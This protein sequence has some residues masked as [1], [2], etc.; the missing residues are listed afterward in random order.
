MN[1]KNFMP[2]GYKNLTELKDVE[3]G[4]G[5]L[6]TQNFHALNG[7]NNIGGDR[8]QS[9]NKDKMGYI[10]FTRPQLNLSPHNMTLNSPLRY[11]VHKD[12][13]SIH[14]YIRCTLDPRLMINKEGYSSI[15]N[16]N[17]AFIP[18]L[19]NTCIS[20]SG[21][22]D[23]VIPTF[24]SAEG[25]RG[26]QHSM[27]DGVKDYLS[28]FDLDCS[29]FNI[30]ESPA[31]ML[32]TAWT[33]YISAVFDD[34]MR[35]YPDFIVER[36]IDYNTRVYRFIMDEHDKYIKQS[37]ACGAAYPL[38][39]SDSKFADY[40]ISKVYNLNNKEINIRLRC[41][42]AEYNDPR[43]LYEFNLS[44]IQ[45]NIIFRDCI[46]AGQKPYYNNSYGLYKVPHELREHYNNYAIPYINLD[47]MELC[48][49][50]DLNDPRVA[51]IHEIVRRRMNYVNK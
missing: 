11:L 15:V 6:E 22:P 31:H 23:K 36:E 38:Q 24:E 43:I 33:D 45:F 35:A 25:A 5:A 29:F 44:I 47:E 20:C 8:V 7:I 49:I 16:N 28:T 14:N 27:A 37:F 18:L 13:N 30:Q 12:P 40:D 17:L 9:A 48:W 2:L 34:R 50:A 42:G 19:T 3:F 32:F 21:W 10:F 39:T 46:K 51:E 41:M 26:E 1:D 4:I